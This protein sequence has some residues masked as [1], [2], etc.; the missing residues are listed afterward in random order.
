MT[1]NVAI[2]SKRMHSHPMKIVFVFLAAFAISQ[3]AIGPVALLVE[4]GSLSRATA[5]SLESTFFLPMSYTANRSPMFFGCLKTYVSLW[6]SSPTQVTTGALPVSNP[7]PYRRVQ[8]GETFPPPI[9]QNLE[10]KVL[11]LPAQSTQ[12]SLPPTIPLTPDR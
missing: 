8:P 10:G 7:L 3:L 1:A 9:D 11:P 6:T 5:T 4:R 2:K 12:T